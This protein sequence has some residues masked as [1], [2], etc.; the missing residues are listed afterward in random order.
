[1]AN[2]AGKIVVGANGAVYVAAVGATGP[3]DATT[4]LN[5]S[6]V[7]LGYVS[8]NGVQVTPSQA[9]TPIMAWQSA[10]PI[11]RIVTTRDLVLDFV[12]REFNESSLPLAMG[13]GTLT[14][15]S[16]GV[17]TFT[18]PD[19]GDVDFRAMVVDWNDDTRDYRLYIPNGQ[20]LDLGAFSLSRTAP[21]ELPI[22]FGLNAAGS[23][24]PWTLFSDDG[25]L[26]S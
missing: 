6:W 25:G 20:V 3:T 21:A 17:F 15:V 24:T 12:L 16:A 4:T 1:M 13:G 26:G 7:E 5:A 10:Y 8:E 11:R 19:A 9:V 18:P 22:K 23:T 2:D 14:E